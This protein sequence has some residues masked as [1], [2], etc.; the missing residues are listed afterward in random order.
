MWPRFDGL[1]TLE[2]GSPGD[3]RDTLNALV[4]AGT[5]R[6]TAGLLA[7]YAQESEELEHVGERLVLV[8]SAGGRLAEVE[9]T[10]VELTPFGQVTWEFADAEGEGFRSIEHWRTGYARY[11]A[12]AGVRV[13]DQTPIV[14]LWFRLVDDEPGTER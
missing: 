14:C 11:W 9:V 10:S 7:D 12:A 4:L 13:D 8:D 2:L 3:F 6:A 1:R 5:K